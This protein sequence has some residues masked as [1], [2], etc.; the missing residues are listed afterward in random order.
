MTRATTHVED[1]RS[2][3]R[4]L[5]AASDAV[6]VRFMAG[7]HRLDFVEPRGPAYSRL[8]VRGPRPY[9]MGLKTRGGRTGPLDEAKAGGGM[10][11]SN[12]ADSFTNRCGWNV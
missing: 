7:S 6:G 4:Y 2:F 3:G 11:L 8:N 5:L 10:I 12:L 9:A 1:R